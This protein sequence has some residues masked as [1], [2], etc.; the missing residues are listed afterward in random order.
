MGVLSCTGP[1]EKKELQTVMLGEGVV[2][3]GGLLAPVE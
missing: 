3:Y 1:L 2:M